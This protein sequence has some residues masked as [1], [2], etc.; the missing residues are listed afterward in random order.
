MRITL[1]EL[2]QRGNPQID[3]LELLSLEGQFY[4]ARLHLE[5]GMQVLSDDQGKTRLLKSAW[6]AQD[7]LGSF[8]VKR[9][10]VVHASAY[11]EMVGLNAPAEPMRIRVQDRRS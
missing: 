3:L 8:D 2:R 10:E 5:D 7:L 4:M 11:D 6:Q 9:T 1:E